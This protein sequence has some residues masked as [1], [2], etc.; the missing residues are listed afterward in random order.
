MEELVLSPGHLPV[1]L[2]VFK[3]RMGT[4]GQ[5]AEIPPQ[6]AREVCSEMVPGY[7]RA[8][9]MGANER[10]CSTQEDSRVPPE[11][12]SLHTDSRYVPAPW[13]HNQAIVLV[14]GSCREQWETLWGSAAG[15]FCTCVVL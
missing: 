4:S 13:N 12:P 7:L 2:V 14:Q 6:C 9:D 1:V 3:F 15:A 8:L 5:A 10:L 11:L